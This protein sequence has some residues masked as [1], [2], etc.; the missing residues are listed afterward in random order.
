MAQ[1]LTTCVHGAQDSKQRLKAMLKSTLPITASAFNKEGTIYAYS[2]RLN[3]ER[4]NCTLNLSS[5]KSSDRREGGSEAAELSF[6]G[7]QKS[8]SSWRRD[9]LNMHLCVSYSHKSSG[10]VP[11]NSMATCTPILCLRLT[12]SLIAG[13]SSHTT[14]GLHEAGLA[15]RLDRVL[16]LVQ[17][18]YDWSRGFQDY[19]PATMTNHIM[20]HS[21]GEQEVKNRS[22]PNRR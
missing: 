4:L 5:F 9:M 3:A 12:P 10:L 7:C 13:E 2:V 21:P 11:T 8:G 19:N 18:S 6:G 20:L 15:L 17:L 22:R 14:P 1:G 16:L